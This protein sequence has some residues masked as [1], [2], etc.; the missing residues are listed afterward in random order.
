MTEKKKPKPGFGPAKKE[1]PKRKLPKKSQRAKRRYVLFQLANVSSSKK[2]FDLVMNR[3]SMEE[4][5]KLGLWFIEFKKETGRGIV[6]FHLG[7]EAKVKKAILSLP[8]EFG[9][10]TLKTSG[11]LKSLR[12]G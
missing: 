8:K 6:R 5:K 7:S 1:K 9:P 2:A 10:K 11:T 4:R 3:F 12:G